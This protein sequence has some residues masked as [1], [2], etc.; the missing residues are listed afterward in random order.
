MS[1]LQ[2]IKQLRAVSGARMVDCKAAVEACGNLDD[3][4]EWLRKKGI[5]RAAKLS[6]RVAEHARPPAP[7]SL[8]APRA[9]PRAPPRAARR[10]LARSSARVPRRASWRSARRPVS[11]CSSR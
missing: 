3:A 11:A 1:T 6:D 9:P 2:L 5:A 4:F 7:A 8:A 10:S